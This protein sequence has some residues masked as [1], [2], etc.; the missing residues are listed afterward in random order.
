MI[1]VT[2]GTSKLPFNRL[3]QA[4][5]EIAKVKGYDILVQ[6]GYSTYVPKYC[7][8]YDFC[9]RKT[10][11]SHI[12]DAVL[13]ISHSGIGSTGDCIRFNKPIILVPREYKYGEAVDKQYELAEYL[14]AEHD[15][16]ICVR[17]VALLPETIERLIGV[18]PIYHYHNCVPDLID[19][20]IKENFLD[21]KL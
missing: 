11:L 14:A 16:I 17:D 15:S 3:L 7:K 13:V 5:D 19:K 21:E 20:F 2:T 6:L 4:V 8:Y 1:F 9:D 18:N 12:Q 10:F